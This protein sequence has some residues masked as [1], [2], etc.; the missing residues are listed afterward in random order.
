M[1]S[2]SWLLR[3]ET[4]LAGLFHFLRKVTHGLLR[5]VAS[6]TACERDSGIIE[7]C[8]EFRSLGFAL[9]PQHQCLLYRILGTVKPAGL[10]GLANECLLVGRQTYFPAAKLSG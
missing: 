4:N 5:D 9:F 6:F 7:A 10:D 3:G 1:E 2:I 8:Q